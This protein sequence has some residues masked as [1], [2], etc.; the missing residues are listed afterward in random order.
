MKYLLDT[1][2]IVLY[3]RENAISESVENTS[4]CLTDITI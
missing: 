3:S 2:L 1:N 4:T